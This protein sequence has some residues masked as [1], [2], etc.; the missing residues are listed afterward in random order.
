MIDY[1][2]HYVYRITN[3]TTQMYYYGD[4]SCNCHPSKDIG[5]NYFSSFGNK[6]FKQDQLN[7]PQDYKYK[8]V[9][10]FETCR[11]DAKQLEVDL[12]KK[13]DVRNHPQFINRANQSSSGFDITG[14]KKSQSQKNKISKSHLGKKH[15]DSH[16]ESQSIY[17]KERMSTDSKFRESITSRFTDWQKE[18]ENPF[19]GK[20]HSEETKKLMRE[21]HADF[22][23]KNHPQYG[24]KHSEES[25]HKMR[26]PRPSIQG[27]KHPQ[28]G[29]PLSEERK[30]K[31][32]KSLMGNKPSNIKLMILIN[33][34][35]NQFFI[36]GNLI[37]FCKENNLT[38]MMFRD[39][40]NHNTIPTKRSK[41]YG[42]TIKEVKRINLK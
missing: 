35:G 41:C 11:K 39:M 2:Y 34:F 36:D 14:I 25:K 24:N 30:A 3:T 7:N 9:K 12:H 26:G 5:F 28:Y 31:I 32:S 10:I 27:E 23:G 37:P 40:L 1:K 6:L 21:N 4:R 18:N 16:K 29:N 19:K 22:K 20:K 17:M 13:F 8:V 38:H 15:S 42:W 33:P